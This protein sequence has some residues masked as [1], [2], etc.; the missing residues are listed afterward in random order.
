MP[1]MDGI[2]ATREIRAAASHNDIPIIGLTAEA[3]VERHAEFREA[4]MNDVLTK[5]FTIDQLFKVL[6]QYG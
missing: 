2:E 4:G 6:S 3:F 1:E 5:P